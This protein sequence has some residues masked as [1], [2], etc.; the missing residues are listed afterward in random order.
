MSKSSNQKMKLLYLL[1]ILREKTDENHALTAAQLIEELDKYDVIAERK[2][3]YNDMAQL[4]DFGYDIENSKTKDKQGYYLCTREFELAE[5]KLLVDAVVASRFISQSKT[6]KLMQ[7]IEGLASRYEAKELGR[8]VY[9][10]QRVKTS[11]E[12]VFYHVDEIH[13]AIQTNHQISFQ[14]FEWKIDRTMQ[15]KRQGLR[16]QVSPFLLVWSEEN[17]YLVAYDSCSNQMK[18]YR[19]DKMSELSA[20]K[21]KCEGRDV[22][23][24]YEPVAFSNKI[25]HMFRGQEETVTLQFK[26][27]LVGVVID[28]FG[29]EITIREKEEDTF[30][31]RVTVEV[32]HQFFGWLAGFGLDVKILMPTRLA[33]EYQDYLQNIANLY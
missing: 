2:S 28:R 6:K 25:F 19:V 12:K 11:N 31:V 4:K 13:R 17:Y 32:S 26:N 10:A 16:Y 20:E 15:L 14:Y 21:Q 7:K 3:I 33:N 9:V 18:H 27:H 30:S 29:K 23:M 22:F 1:K 5:L 24:E 8:Q